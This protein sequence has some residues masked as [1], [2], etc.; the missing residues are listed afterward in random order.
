MPVLS[1]VRASSAQATTVTSSTLAPRSARMRSAELP[2]TSRRVTLEV[3]AIETCPPAA[4]VTSV[5]CVG[6]SSVRS[7]ATVAE[8]PA[9]TSTTAR[10]VAVASIQAVAASPAPISRAARGPSYFSAGAAGV[11]T[12][13]AMSLTRR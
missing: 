1:R 5:A 7:L 8:S 4:T 2:G 13:S 11:G 9:A 6:S 3:T 12:S 10:S